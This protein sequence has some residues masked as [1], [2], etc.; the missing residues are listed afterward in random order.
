MQRGIRNF[1]SLL[2][3]ETTTT[4]PMGDRAKRFGRDLALAEKRNELLAHRYYYY[5]KIVRKNYPDTLQA[6]Q[7]EFFLSEYQISR[8]IADSG[9]VLA[10]LKKIQ[11]ATKYFMAMYPHLVW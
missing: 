11:P 2:F 8:V 3:E 9:N 7:L 10:R 4:A 6:L 5:V 1:Q